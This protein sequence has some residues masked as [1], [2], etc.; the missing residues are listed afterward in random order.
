[1]MMM[2]YINYHACSELSAGIHGNIAGQELHSGW[3]FTM[4]TMLQL[5][6]QP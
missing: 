3:L 5:M 2:Y 4:H 6:L 1:M